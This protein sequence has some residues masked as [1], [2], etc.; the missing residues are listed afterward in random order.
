MTQEQVN[1]FLAVRGKYFEP[2]HLP[3]IREQLLATDES[4]A[5]ALNYLEFQDPTLMLIISILGGAIGL[6]RFLLGDTTMGVLKLITAGGCG[7]WA[8]VD[9]FLIMG[10]TRKKNFFTL[11][12]FLSMR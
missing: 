8:I 10:L 12:Q 1:L 11:D 3:Y 2:E 4:K 7:I 6:D 5:Q 9:L